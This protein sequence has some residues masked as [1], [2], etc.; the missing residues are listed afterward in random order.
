[1]ITYFLLVGV[2]F[3]SIAFRFLYEHLRKQGRLDPRDKLVFAL[4]FL[5]M[6]AMWASWSNLCPLDPWKI[7]FP[8]WL[9]WTGMAANLLGWGLFLGGAIQLRGLENIEHLATT[10]LYAKFSHPMYTGFLLW[11]SGLPLWNN[12]ATSLV[13][14]AVGAAAV[15]RWRSQ[16]ELQL[17]SKYGPAWRDYKTRTWL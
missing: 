16:E 10:G 6:C 1:M 2:F 12:S 7:E 8:T 3:A 17:E 9:R 13:V 14:G 15:W 5:D 4:V 11:L